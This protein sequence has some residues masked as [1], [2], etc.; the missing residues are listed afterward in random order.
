MNSVN[1]TTFLQTRRIGSINDWANHH[2]DQGRPEQLAAPLKTTI[3]TPLQRNKAR[4]NFNELCIDVGASQD[5]N[6]YKKI[7]QTR[8]ACSFDYRLSLR[9]GTDLLSHVLPQYHRLWWA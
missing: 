4:K 8:K 5:Q 9:F 3:N 2:K 1:T 7:Q 6:P